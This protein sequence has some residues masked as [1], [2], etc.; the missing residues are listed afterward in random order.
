MTEHATI[1]SI[2]MDCPRPPSHADL[3]RALH[4][5]CAIGQR[6]GHDQGYRRGFEAGCTAGAINT[7]RTMEKVHEMLERS[8]LKVPHGT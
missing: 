7:V 3:L 2:A 5:A 1:E 6:M 8:P 4:Q